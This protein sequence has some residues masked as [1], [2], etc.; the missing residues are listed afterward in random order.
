MKKFIFLLVTIATAMA[1]ADDI[2]LGEP[3]YGGTGCPQGTVGT[4]LSPDNKVLSV[5]FDAFM[6]QAGKGA[7][8]SIDRKTCSLAVPIHVP[9]GLSVSVLK[10]DYRGYTFVPT[11]AMARFSVEYFL[12]SFN[13]ESTGP[14]GSRTFLGPVDKDYIIS[15]ELALSGIVWS[16][17]GQDVNLRINTS[18][19]AKT[20]TKNQ[21]VLATV[22]SADIAAGMVYHL[23]WKKCL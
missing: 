15:N 22:D 5:I 3:A 11:G 4:T 7:G 20:N 16:A 1:S 2:A 10:V 9:Q 21:D 8:V 17:C 23:Q 12:K 13:S 18:M 6:A 19:L 14:K